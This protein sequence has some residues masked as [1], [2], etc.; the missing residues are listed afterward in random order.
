MLD[1]DDGG[2]LDGRSGEFR[3]SGEKLSHR[4][5]FSFGEGPETRFDCGSHSRRFG[6]R[7]VYE[8]SSSLLSQKYTPFCW[9]FEGLPAVGKKSRS[10]ALLRMIRMAE[11]ND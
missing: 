6:L 11:I 8:T 9:V 1:V 3:G 5:L 10:F 4:C 2:I 7:V